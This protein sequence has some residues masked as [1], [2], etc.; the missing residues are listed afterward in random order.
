MSAFGK[1]SDLVFRQMPRT[2][3]AVARGLTDAT[4]A[5]ARPADQT[6]DDEKRVI[7]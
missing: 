5:H 2:R 3:A 4:I 1:Y 7:A 6:Q